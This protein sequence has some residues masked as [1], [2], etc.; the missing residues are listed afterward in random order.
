MPQVAPA[1]GPTPADREKRRD[2][3]A[4]KWRATALLVVAAVVYVV[5]RAYED[6][7][8]WA[9]YVRAT[10]EAAMVGGLADWFAVTAL[11]RHPLGIPIPHTAIIPR[12]KDQLGASLA[13][14]VEDNFLSDDVIT[15][16]LRQTSIARRGA[17]WVVDPEHAATVSRHAGAA[18]RGGLDVLRD[19]EVQDVVERAV[20]ARVRAVRAAPLAGRTLDIL[21][22]NGRHQEVLDA[23]LRSIGRFLDENRTMLRSKFARESPWWVP[24]SIDDRIFDKIYTGLHTLIADVTD[25]PE[26]ELRTYLDQRLAHLAAELRTSPELGARGEELKEEL[27]D[28][29]AV[30]RWT[31]ALWA[32]LKKSL[33]DQS[34]DPD[35]E[36]RHRIE[37]TVRSI[38]AAVLEDAV[39]ADKVD[40]WVEG[41]VLY[42]VDSYRHEIADVIATTVAKWDPHEASRR[43]E[44][45]VGRD[46]QFIRINGTL[47]GGLAGLAIHALS[48][49]VL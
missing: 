43:I 46:L 1:L 24:E 6:G 49:L 26:H 36:L 34:T 30:R 2:L 39:L 10:A 44:L 42:V 28:H 9:G 20:L 7:H 21:T 12:R 29:P 23:A 5:A 13:S 25:D 35:S 38:G 3:R 18:L 16:K 47:V 33:Q 17:R 40:R 32:D 48:S 11:F 41:A 22:A 15:E 45:Q 19:E 8:G 4:M 37:I 27:L 31:G 14:F